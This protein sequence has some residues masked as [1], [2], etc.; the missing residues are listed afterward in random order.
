MKVFKCLF[1][2][3]IA[4]HLSKSIS[5]YDGRISSKG[6][7]VVGIAVI[8][9]VVLFVAFLDYGVHH[10]NRKPKTKRKRKSRQFAKDFRSSR[11]NEIKPKTMQD[12]QKSEAQSSC[13]KNGAI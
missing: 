11:R 13:M 7:G 1:L 12:I 6:I 8:I 2:L 5:A 3:L 4:V 9:S 10:R